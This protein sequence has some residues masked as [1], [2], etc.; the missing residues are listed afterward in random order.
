MTH[1]VAEI[2]PQEAKR[3]ADAGELLLLD[4]RESDEWKAGHASYAMH[5]PLG[6]L[7]PSVIPRDR[8]VVAVCRSGNRSGVAAAVLSQAGMT[9]SNLAG[10][11]KAWATAGLPVVRDDG[12]PGDV[13]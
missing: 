12:T 13:A 5:L 10:G 6:E 7:D 1:P 2:N 8:P 3:A 11:M 4:V 9:V